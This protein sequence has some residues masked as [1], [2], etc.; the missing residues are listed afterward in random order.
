[1]FPGG[2]RT[3]IA[4][5]APDISE[6]DKKKQLEKGGAYGTTAEDAAR[7]IVRAIETGKERV[8]IGP[9]AKL[10]DALT[11]LA[12]RSAGALMAALMKRAGVLVADE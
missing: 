5:N 8:T 11:R 9:D 6:A 7:T 12:P 3:N 1:M 2:V 10:L 4:A